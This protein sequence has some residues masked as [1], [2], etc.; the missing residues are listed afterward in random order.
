MHACTKTLGLTALIMYSVCAPILASA[1]TAPTPLPVSN[2]SDEGDGGNMVRECGLKDPG[3]TDKYSYCG[4]D[5]RGSV[6]YVL[7][8][9]SKAAS[10]KDGLI[11][12]SEDNIRWL[13]VI[14]HGPITN[15][16]LEEISNI[17]SIDTVVLVTAIRSNFEIPSS[18]K[19]N[20]VVTYNPKYLENLETSKTFDNALRD[21]NRLV[22]KFLEKGKKV[23]IVVDNP[24][25]PEPNDCIGRKT[26]FETINRFL[27]NANCT[28]SLEIFNT[29]IK[30]YRAV[31][32]R[33]QS[34]HPD[35]VRIFD[36]TDI[37][38]DFNTGKCEAIKNG[39]PMYSYSDHISYY[40]ARLVGRKLNDF[41]L[42]KK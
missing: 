10:L 11:K 42:Q 22:D 13:A 36:P 40:A 17:S 15:G 27:K 21:F 41:I 39:Q 4:I 37:Y 35:S 1:Q 18:T 38:C 26:A 5:K 19:V 8:G 6:R 16:L 31:L 24:A 33:I 32:D 12:V 23:I 30:R 3:I 29:Q 25:L 9:D 20:N 34:T 28:V 2:A 14:P 7:L